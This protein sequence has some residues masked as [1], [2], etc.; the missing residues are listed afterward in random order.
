[1][2]SMARRRKEVSNA[3]VAAI[4]TAWQA[5]GELRILI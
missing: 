4:S 3:L 1:M 2:A 5:S